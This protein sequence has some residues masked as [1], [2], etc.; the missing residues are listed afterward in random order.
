MGNIHDMKR[1]KGHPDGPIM[2]LGNSPQKKCT[3]TDVVGMKDLLPPSLLFPP[4][5]LDPFSAN[6]NVFGTS[7]PEAKLSSNEVHMP[8]SL[9]TFWCQESVEE[10]L[11]RN[12]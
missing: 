5:A 10:K 6:S 3:W 4:S 11:E 12:S 8:G 2:T 9:F 1:A 7:V